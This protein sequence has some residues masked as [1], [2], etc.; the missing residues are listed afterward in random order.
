MKTVIY[1]IGMLAG[2]LPADVRKLEGEQMGHV[3][4][5]HDAYLVIEDGVISEF[6]EGRCLQDRATPLAAGGGAQACLGGVVLPTSATGTMTAEVSVCS[7]HCNYRCPVIIAAKSL[8]HIFR[9]IF[10]LVRVETVFR[11]RAY[12]VNMGAE[13][14]GRLVRICDMLSNDI[15]SNAPIVNFFAAQPRADMAAHRI[16]LERRR[17]YRNHFLQ[18]VD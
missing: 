11:T 8:D 10:W 2:I 17:R 6:G 14:Q 7:Y 15:V 18:Q 4:C 16:L 5:L 13:H 12:R 3:E 9:T 1:N